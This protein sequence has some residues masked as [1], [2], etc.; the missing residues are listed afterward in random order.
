L[1]KPCFYKKP[2]GFLK[3]LRLQ[4]ISR[5]CKILSFTENQAD[6]RILASVEISAPGKRPVFEEKSASEEK[7]A[8]LGKQAARLLFRLGGISNC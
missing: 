4:K 3:S 5:I 2:G 6:D 8:G 1:R 7:P